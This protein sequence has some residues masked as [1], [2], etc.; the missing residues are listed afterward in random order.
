MGGAAHLMA[1]CCSREERMVEEVT[2]F[3]CG[4]CGSLKSTREEAAKHCLCK[5]GRPARVPAGG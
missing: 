3:K 4:T 2:M 1:G 5:C